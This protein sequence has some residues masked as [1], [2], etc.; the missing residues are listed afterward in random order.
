MKYILFF[1]IIFGL[2]YLIIVNRVKIADYYT[3]ISNKDTSKEDKKKNDFIWGTSINP[4]PTGKIDQKELDGVI[5]SLKDLGVKYVRLE[6]PNDGQEP[7]I[8]EPT[9]KKVFDAG[10]EVILLIQP[11]KAYNEISDPYQDGFDIAQKISKHYYYINYFQLGNEPA[12]DAIKP[13]WSGIVGSAYEPD[14]YQKVSTWL[15]G[16]SEGVK[17][18]NS[19]AKKII[20]GHWLH[21]AFVDM[22]INDGI[23]FDI[24]GWDWFA[25]KSN[26]L[27]VETDK[28]EVKV[29]DRIASLGKDVWIME[30]GERGDDEKAQAE[31]YQIRLDEIAKSGKVKGII[32]LN[33]YDQAF[34]LGGPNQFNGI[35]NLKKNSA[36]EF[37]LGEPRPA[38]NILKEFIANN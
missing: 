18:G 4:F 11:K 26:I 17:I 32:N 23:Q 6:Y 36:G 7:A 16:A 20:T 2:S 1:I 3:Q 25:E 34:L 8:H 22:L 12:T 13:G 38:Y 29:L 35:L 10:F 37:E 19:Q 28:G 9:I 15:K 27:S 5:A 30:F 24:I 21:I 31:Y 33:L 14:R